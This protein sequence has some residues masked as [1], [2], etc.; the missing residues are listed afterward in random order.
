MGRAR[1]G[2]SPPELFSRG[3]TAVGSGSVV[4]AGQ[5]TNKINYLEEILN[6]CIRARRSARA[7]RPLQFGNEV[8]A[9]PGKAAVAVGLAAEM[10]VS[11]RALVDRLGGL[12]AAA[13][14][15]R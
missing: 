14:V 6:N 2:R 10:T 1:F 4:A 3:A 12:Q 15:G 13:G 7:E 9:L 8:E 11:G 5:T